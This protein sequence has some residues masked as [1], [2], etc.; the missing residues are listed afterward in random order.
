MRISDAASYQRLL[1]NLNMLNSRLETATEQVSS[2]RRLNHLH[3]G[4]SAAAEMVQL[5]GQLAQIDQFQ[6]NADQ[7]NY[8]LQF[9]DS[10]L[11]SVYDL[12]T[13]I[14]TRGSEAAS[15]LADEQS[16]A[17]L[18]VEI[19]SQRDQILSLANTDVQGRFLFAGSQSASPA[20]SLSGDTAQ[21]HGDNVI[22][23]VDINN[24]LSVNG[25]IPGSTAFQRVF[26]TVEQLLAAIDA[27]DE[28]A[29]RSSLSGFAGALSDVNKVRA[30]LGVDL[31]KIEN[32]SLA[33]QMQQTSITARQ[34]NLSNADMA[35]AVTDL[36]Q[37]QTA[38]QA[39]LT[40][41]SMIHRY[42]LFD[43][44]V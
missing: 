14:F 39:S 9:S 28:T 34:A 19:R 2:S 40:A 29:I 6:T 26:E 21:Y 27:G 23:T 43:F 3:D 33:R 44:L 32:S 35:Q 17:I 20:F 41:G 31:A 7:S 25:N 22:N 4:P 38:L 11:T 24:G 1:D 13:A 12:V 5:N 10:V 8:L 37:A 42:N 15:S 16:R 36:T 18:A 30:A